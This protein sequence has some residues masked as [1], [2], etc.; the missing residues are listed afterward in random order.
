MAEAEAVDAVGVE[1]IGTAGVEAV[2]I[3][4]TAAEVEVVETVGE[5]VIHIRS[6]LDG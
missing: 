1:G 4:A 5:R 3:M 2:T 6:G